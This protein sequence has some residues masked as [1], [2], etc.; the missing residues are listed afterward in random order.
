[1]LMD[2]FRRFLHRRG[3]RLERDRQQ[4]GESLLPSNSKSRTVKARTS[5]N[6]SAV[7]GLS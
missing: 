3:A 5:L 6:R 2:Q 4:Q 7:G 1:M